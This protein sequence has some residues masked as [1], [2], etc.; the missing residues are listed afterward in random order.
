[1][2]WVCLVGLVG[3]ERMGMGRMRMMLRRRVGR[4]DWRKRLLGRR[5]RTCLPRDFWKAR[6]ERL[7]LVMILL[8]VE[9]WKRL[10]LR[11]SLLHYM[12][13]G[14]SRVMMAGGPRAGKIVLSKR[15][16]GSLKPLLMLRERRRRLMSR[17]LRRHLRWKI[18]WH[19]LLLSMH[20][21]LGGEVGVGGGGVGVSRLFGSLCSGGWV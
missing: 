19:L 5:G 1:M 4:K 9:S 18:R 20:L 11:E 14:Q 17:M 2:L 13:R 8:V 16:W 12:L 7:L 21:R 6:M 15:A 10:L 3:V